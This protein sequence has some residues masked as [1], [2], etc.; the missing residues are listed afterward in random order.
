MNSVIGAV[1]DLVKTLLPGGY[2]FLIVG[3]T[4]GVALLFSGD[5]WRKRG[6][7]WLV[8]LVG[9]Y[10]LLSTPLVAVALEGI[11]GAGSPRIERASEAEGSEL[12]V[13]LT[14]GG[15]T[16]RAGEARPYD[17]LS[18]ASVYRMLE[19]ERLHRLLGGTPLLISGGPAGG[20]P[21]GRPEAEA[22]R[23]DL[24]GRGILPDLVA[25]E[26]T[27]PDTHEQ[28][29][30]VGEWVRERGVDSFVLVTSA[31]HM[32]RALGAFRAEGMAPIPSAALEPP[33][34]GPRL[35]P[36]SEALDRSYHAVREMVGL[37]YYAARGWL[38]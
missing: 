12:I 30:R 10:L 36:S 24:I 15:V 11:L 3:L 9:S 19:A 13:V 2:P 7:T 28:A 38:R 32:R 14:G 34:D 8:V 4:A 16:L 33:P 27:S 18:R 1:S 5:R 23:D 37:A 35:M 21:A 25:V 26:A 6:R 29:V 31:Q 22:M 20:V 17:I